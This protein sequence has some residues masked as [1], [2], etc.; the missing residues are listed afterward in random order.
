MGLIALGLLLFVVA[1]VITYLRPP[2]V[3]AM[4]VTPTLASLP[5]SSDL[6][7]LKSPSPSATPLVSPSP[8]PAPTMTSTWTPSPIATRRATATPKP[9]VPP[10]PSSI[11]LPVGPT[12]PPL[13]ATAVVSSPIPQPPPMPAVVQPEGTIN[14]L[15]LGM[16]R[17]SGQS[18]ARTDVIVI[19]SLFPE[20]PSVSLLSV[21]R[22][23]YAWIPGWGLDKINTAYSRAGKIG[24]PGGGPALVKATIAYNF[25][26]QIHY[27]AMVDFTSYRNIVDAVDGVDVVVECPFHDTYPD[28]ESPTGQ[29]DIDLEP[30]IHHLDG[31]FA[32]WYVRS[33]WNT[34]DFDRHR[35][36]QQVLLAVWQQAKS[37]GMLLRIPELWQV[38]Q[39][40]VETDLG[41]TELLYLGTIALRLDE[42]DVHSYF[43]RGSQL[44]TPWTA[45]NGGY[46]LVPDLEAVHAFVQRAM[47]PLTD[48]RMPR[49][50]HRVV[51]ANGTGNPA[52]GDVAAYRLRLEGFEV[53]SVIDVPFEPRTRVIDFTTTPKGSPLPKLVSLYHLQPGDVT[54]QPTSDST[55]DFQIILG[56]NYNP[57]TGTGTAYWR[58]TPTPPPPP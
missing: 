26:I 47:Q 15:L 6:S 41:L 28:P 20:G 27:Y 12:L 5:P 22:D 29:T 8:P 2:V 25:G 38:Y 51:L 44:I 36:Q 17:L 13:A 34:S 49:Q 7:P 32:L 54:S 53:T 1:A 33:R 14:I 57:C 43:I 11:V 58:A 9:S 19:V 56:A 45:P 30:G 39:E 4:V 23:Y 18:V 35:R 50:A 10:S 55:V 52:F 46:V 37:A 16:D 24:Y 21:P 48:S 40:Y 3:P 42:R 31:K